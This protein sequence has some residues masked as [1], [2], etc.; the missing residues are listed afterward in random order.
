MMTQKSQETIDK[1]KE[2]KNKVY[3]EVIERQYAILNYAFTLFRGNR[4]T[5]FTKNDVMEKAD[6]SELDKEPEEHSIKRD[7][8]FY[9]ESYLL[10]QISSGKGKRYTL[11]SHLNI[12]FPSNSDAMSDL[13]RRVSGLM[14][15]NPNMTTY[16]SLI[17][18]LFPIV[19]NNE[20]K[21]FLS[22]DGNIKQSIIDTIIDTSNMYYKNQVPLQLL[23]KLIKLEAKFNI[24]IENE[25]ISIVMNNRYL[26]KLHI[27]ENGDIS[28]IFDN[29]SVKLSEL[30]EIKSL[31]G[32][33]DNI[34]LTIYELKEILNK[35]DKDLQNHLNNLFSNHLTF[36]NLFFQAF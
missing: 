19:E 13:C 22:L 17:N 24:K 35:L 3:F 7:L 11:E 23:L 28:L 1:N 36:G 27:Y 30:D 21:S 32:C 9:V 8:R 6:F 26:K 12:D 33:S 5:V 14:Y 20:L 34:D 18:G 15:L 4:N 10:A 29:S 31:T 16:D 25:D 2:K